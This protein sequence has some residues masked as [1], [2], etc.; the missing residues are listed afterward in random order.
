MCDGRIGVTVAFALMSLAIGFLCCEGQRGPTGPEGPQGESGIPR[1]M[2]IHAS[3]VSG[4]SP[5]GYTYWTYSITLP[6][7][8]AENGVIANLRG[9][10]C[11]S[12]TWSSTT[13]VGCRIDS[14]SV[15]GTRVTISGW[16]YIVD[17][18]CSDYDYIVSFD[19]IAF[20]A[21]TTV[22]FE[23]KKPPPIESI[24]HKRKAS[25]EPAY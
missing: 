4:N 1:R 12:E 25:R 9:Y 5:G 11:V 19:I 6:W 18:Y 16:V 24:L 8:P 22:K 13:D 3:Y 7:T 23:E 2:F 10:E 17:K 21:S 14:I 15:S 20:D